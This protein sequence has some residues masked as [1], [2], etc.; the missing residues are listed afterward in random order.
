M[1]LFKILWRKMKTVYK[2]LFK[3]LRFWSVNN[4]QI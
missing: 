1:G 3:S 2:T 4:G